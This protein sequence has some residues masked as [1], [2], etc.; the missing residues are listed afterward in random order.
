MI[1]TFNITQ[2]RNEIKRLVSK[3]EQVVVKAGDDEFNRKIFENKDVDLVVG[4][5]FN[6]KDK[7]KQRDSGLNEVLC[8]LAKE[9]TIA[10]GVAIDRIASLEK[11]EKAKV[12]ARVRQNLVLSKRVGNIVVGYLHGYDVAGVRS[13][14]AVLSR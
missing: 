11:Q 8:K 2:A 9:N 14:F 3:G 6:K 1:I 10:V 4:L 5:E 7:L 12:L 13:L